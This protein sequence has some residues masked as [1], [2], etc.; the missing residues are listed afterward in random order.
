MQKARLGILDIEQFKRQVNYATLPNGTVTDAVMQRGGRYDDN[1]DYMYMAEMGIWFENFALP[2]VINEC[3]MQSYHGTI[4]LFP[5]WNLQE[6]AAFRTLR[7][8][9]AF[10]VSAQVLDGRIQPV[11]IFS[12]QG[13]SCRVRNPWKDCQVR[14]VSEHGETILSG[15][16]LTFNTQKNTSYTLTPILAEN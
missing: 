2:A 6:N 14:I 1:T 13:L 5:N 12:E 15:E 10:L 3:L 8:R 9:G 4:H 16:M 7:A 11:T